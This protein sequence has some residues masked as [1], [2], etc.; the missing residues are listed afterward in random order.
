MAS[1]IYRI[2]C[3]ANG[4]FYLGSSS[5]IDVRWQGHLSLLR[6][7]AH[8]SRRLQQA[9]NEFGETAFE[10]EIIEEVPEAQLENREQEYLNSTEC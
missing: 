5:N 2:V 4:K 3:R 1:G 7:G 6:R 8:H 10:L 9:W